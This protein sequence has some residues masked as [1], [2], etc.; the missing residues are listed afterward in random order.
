LRKQG[1]KLS[2]S[3]PEKSDA[4]WLSQ[5]TIKRAAVWEGK[6]FLSGLQRHVTQRAA[7]ERIIDFSNLVKFFK[8]T[9]FIDPANPHFGEAI[10]SAPGF[11]PANIRFFKWF[12]DLC[13]ELRGDLP[14]TTTRWWFWSPYV[15]HSD[16]TCLAASADD[17][18][19]Y[20]IIFPPTK[21]LAMLTGC[22]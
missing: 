20:Y 17:V 12:R 11:D 1:S 4:L 2:H 13:L 15:P 10:P 9:V 3:D 16:G 22:M 21:R 7:T 5:T 18:L 14:G 8:G 6:V 19:F